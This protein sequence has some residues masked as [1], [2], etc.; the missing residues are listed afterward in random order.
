MDAILV[1]DSTSASITLGDRPSSLARVTASSV[2]DAVWNLLLTMYGTKSAPHS[3]IAYMRYAE[4]VPPEKA[5]PILPFSR[6]KSLSAFGT[7]SAMLTLRG[8]A[9]I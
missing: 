9:V 6:R 7:A 8:F 5:S 1:S 4:S 2:S 3:L